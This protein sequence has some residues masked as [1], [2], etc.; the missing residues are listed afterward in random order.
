M[1][2]RLTA[3][4][5]T[6]LLVAAAT[7]ALV[8]GAIGFAAAGDKGEV[9]ESFGLP[10]SRHG[11][12][13]NYTLRVDG[14]W[15]HDSTVP[16]GPVH[17]AM[18]FQWQEDGIYR[19]EHGLLRQADV[20]DSSFVSYIHGGLELV[21]GFEDGQMQTETQHW[22][23]QAQRQWLQPGDTSASA[24]GMQER[25]EGTY[26]H[27]LT[28]AGMPVP[29]PLASDVRTDAT[30]IQYPAGPYRDC[31]VANPFQGQDLPV[32][33][34][35]VPKGGCSLRNLPIHVAD[36]TGYEPLGIQTVGDVDAL[37]FRLHGH[38]FDLAGESDRNATLDL[39]FVPD[40]PY[41]VQATVQ[42]SLGDD[43]LRGVLELVAYQRGDTPRLRADT[44]AD[45]D[46]APALE[47][48]PAET[49]GPSDEGV[50]H[51]FPLSVA[52]AQA[53]DDLTWSD[54]RDYL[55]GHPD[56]FVTAAEFDEWRM[57]D[58]V[59]QT[60]DLA[61]A[62]P[63]DDG[64]AFRITQEEMPNRRGLV[65]LPLYT[66][67]YETEFSFSEFWLRYAPDAP[68]E[69]FPTTA[70]L[71]DRW[72]A[73]VPHGQGRDA[74]PSWG[75][76]LM[77]LDDP[78]SGEQH[79]FWAGQ[80]T[81]QASGGRVEPARPTS[82]MDA[83]VAWSQLDVDSRGVTHLVL[84]IGLKTESRPDLGG[85]NGSSSSGIR[86]QSAASAEFVGGPWSLPT[87]A[88]AVG[89]GVLAALAALLYWLWPVLKGLPAVGL[90]SRLRGDEVE[91]HP[92][93]GKLVAA[94]EA[95]PGIHFQELRRR[96]GLA[97]G[98]AVHHLRI[99]EEAG[100]IVGRRADG[101][102]CYFARG[103]DAKLMSAL[104]TL[105]SQSARS[106]LAAVRERP[107]ASNRDVASR[108]GLSPAT[109]SYHLRR[110][111]EAGLVA[112]ERRGGATVLRLTRVGRDAVA[113]A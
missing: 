98:A 79:R 20:L 68:P 21:T 78:C 95:Q 113:V 9:P 65:D 8:A 54:L 44:L 93:R 53:R 99:L 82:A 77:C 15:N 43:R 13:A 64:F 85:S 56:A 89:A 31:L 23:A 7:F 102:T 35:V 59:Y 107:T 112:S 71:L 16:E 57:P 87:P 70:S 108:T 46:A 58:S 22:F 47:W 97:N 5:L 40:V 45:R 33:G 51:P 88:Q 30:V 67:E 34:A 25:S 2:S 109:V 83:A 37:A 63:G 91:S 17:G 94:I 74:S 96:A 28:A 55:D 105:R 52:W 48:A 50:D 4:S 103:V 100:R 92:V 84:D 41:P 38:F 101:Y 75:F 36:G 66:Y 81:F 104:P 10:A 11:D 90:F 24:Y 12:H 61:V 3:R 80:D 32:E 1:A 69:T 86:L 62:S 39:A 72:G 26:S 73:Y 106:I 76:R 29:Y 18:V 6:A 42:A 60:W 19:D 27:D 110:L 111:R 49:W 14:D